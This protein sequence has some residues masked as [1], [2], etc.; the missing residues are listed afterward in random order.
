MRWHALRTRLVDAAARLRSRLTARRVLLGAAALL[1]IFT[2]LIGLEALVRAHLVSP[3]DRLPTGLYSRSVGWNGDAHQATLIAPLPGAS[4]EWREPLS[5]DEIPALLQDAVVAVEDKRFRDHSGVDLTRIGGAMLANIRSGG[6]AEGGSTITQQLA[7]NLYLDARRTPLRKVR[8]AAIAMVLEHRY[9]KDQILEA[10]LNEIYLGHD[11]GRAIHGVGAAARYY[12]GRD[13]DHLS[14]SEM[15]TLAGMIHS[16]NRLAPSR[17]P[18]DARDRR[19]V[20]LRLMAEQG[21]IDADQLRRAERTAIASRP[22]PQQGVDARYFRDAAAERIPDHLP[23]R[24]AAV[25]TTLDI[26]MQRAAERAVRDGLARLP[27]RGAEAALVA[28]DPRNGDV[29]ALVGGA[30]YGRSQFN[31]ATVARRQPGSAFKPIVAL[32][33]LARRGDRQPAFTLAS[34]VADE[35][36]RVPT[37]DGVWQPANYDG[38]FRGD[39]TFREALEQSLNVPFARIGLAVGPR[40]IVATARRLGIRS[41]LTAVPALALG[42]GE[43]TLLELVQAYGVFATEGDLA[44]TR[45]I[46]AT[47]VGGDQLEQRDPPRIERVAD[48]SVTYLVTSALEGAVRE[49]TGAALEGGA[50]AGDIAGKTGTSND[51]RD[52]WFLAYTPR[53]VVGVWVG[54]DDGGSLHRTGAQAALP[55]VARFLDRIDLGRDRFARPDDVVEQWVSDAESAWPVPCERRELFL[56]GTAPGGV[57]CFRL[58]VDDDWEIDLDGHWRDQLRRGVVEWLRQRIEREL[59]LRH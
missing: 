48:S 29:L 32:A 56:A 3:G 35:P 5:L 44:Q 46:T 18:R 57:G 39:V 23:D 21:M 55:I 40:Q 8:E 15:A 17:H 45:M 47:R 16:P 51:W 27:D 2:A 24:G 19:D 58:A 9:S 41:P 37:D 11:Q 20:V 54:R 4:D 53:L 10:Y 7:K 26:A 28:I 59:D 50:F 43:V 25:Y 49:G 22:H 31:R 14:L 12:F 30:D 42:S 33:A 6:I 34:T 36:L 52:A 13:V 1:T 38:S